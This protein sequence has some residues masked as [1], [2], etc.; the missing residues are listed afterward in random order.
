MSDTNLKETKTMKQVITILAVI[1]LGSGAAVALGDS[2]PIGPLPAGP[3]SSI[4]AQRREL[5]AVALPQRSGGRV[6][7]LA[8]P[9]NDNVLHQVSEANVGASVV[10][11]FRARGA[12]ATTVSLALT[13]SDTSTTALESRRFQVRVR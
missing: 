9:I 10:I 4:T 12:G 13:K 5:V 11:I 2:S 8:R 3:V 1:A 6:W 7:R